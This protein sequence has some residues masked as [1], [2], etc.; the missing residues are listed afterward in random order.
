MRFLPTS[1]LL[2]LPGLAL[3]TAPDGRPVRNSFI[4]RPVVDAADLVR[5]V[6][7]DPVVADR[8]ERHFSMDRASVLRFLSTLHRAR[9]VQAG[10]F[11]IYSV[12]PDGHVKMH[13]G[14]IPKGEPMFINR[15]NRPILVVR[16]GNPVVL[17]PMAHRANAAPHIGD[18]ANERRMT[19]SEALFADAE[20]LALVPA[21]PESPLPTAVA[22]AVAGEPVLEVNA[23]ERAILPVASKF[24]NLEGLALALPI[25]GLLSHHPSSSGGPAA[26]VPEP[27]PLAA[28]ALG[29]VGLACRRRSD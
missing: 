15:A 1:V 22:F 26:A 2:A 21:V 12:P 20:P 27:A 23:M 3:A 5:H 11:T 18:M 13:I 4:D 7:T 14:R 24:P 6:R 29:L 10:T 9:L 17:G 25:L 16:C 19:P 28:L 8:Y